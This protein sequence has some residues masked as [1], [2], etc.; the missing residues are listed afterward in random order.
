MN[1]DHSEPGMQRYRL[2]VSKIM[3]GALF[4]CWS[5]WKKLV[6]GLLP[7]AALIFTVGLA[8]Q[9]S[10]IRLNNPAS[11]FFVALSLLLFAKFAVICHRLVLVDF[12]ASSQ[13]I[14]PFSWS[15]RETYYLRRMIIAYALTSVGSILISLVPL[16]MVA[17]SLPESQ[18]ND[19]NALLP[20][21][22]LFAG[23]P[24]I[25][26]LARLSLVFPATAVD[27][28]TGIGWAWNKSRGN[29]LRIAVIVGLIPWLS[30]VVEYFMTKL[31]PGIF[32][33][34]A[35]NIINYVLIAV[36]LTALSLAY[37]EM[38]QPGQTSKSD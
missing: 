1:N 18:R 23:I 11:I 33:A 5:N 4:I 6:K 26:L 27:A 29:G 22:M 17:Q 36:E 20:F 19:P 16:A 30:L 10:G 35:A 3:V 21:A 28:Q 34:I 7:T 25:Y 32:A 12:S 15:L 2:P 9:L 8:W 37:R 24:A 38:V 14:P 13:W 31:M